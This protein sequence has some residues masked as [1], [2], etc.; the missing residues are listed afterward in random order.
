MFVDDYIFN[1]QPW[2]INKQIC[3]C[4]K[5][6]N[7]NQENDENG[8]IMDCSPSSVVTC[9]RE[10]PV[11]PPQNCLLHGRRWKVPILRKF[12]KT[13]RSPYVKV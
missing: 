10:T 4:R 6:E 7:K 3:V 1:E 11:T 12:R 2:N 9:K 13:A 8:K 5:K